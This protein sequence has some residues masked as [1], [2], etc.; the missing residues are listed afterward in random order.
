MGLSSDEIAS[1]KPF[2]SIPR[3]N[4]CIATSRG[5]EREN[6]NLN[7]PLI[8][9]QNHEWIIIEWLFQSGPKPALATAQSCLCFF[10]H[11]FNWCLI[12]HAFC[13]QWFCFVLCTRLCV[14]SSRAHFELK[15][16]MKNQTNE[17]IINKQTKQA[18]HKHIMVHS[19]QRHRD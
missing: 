13:L 6:R 1:T 5:S 9:C 7:K 18:K 8:R 10:Q 3:C 2:H 12:G 14:D 17:T 4:M 16:K 19:T 15:K 11:V